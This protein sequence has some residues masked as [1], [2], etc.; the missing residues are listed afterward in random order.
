ML[1][2]VYIV[3]KLSKN[4]RRFAFVRFLH[5]SDEKRMEN[6]LSAQELALPRI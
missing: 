5:V 2:D 1:A 6:R 3:R 4:G